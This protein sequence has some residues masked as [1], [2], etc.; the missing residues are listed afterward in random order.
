MSRGCSTII[1]KCHHGSLYGTHCIIVIWLSKKMLLCLTNVVQFNLNSA[2]IHFH[3][4]I[5]Y[6]MEN[7]NRQTPKGMLFSFELPFF[8][9]CVQISVQNDIKSHLYYLIIYLPDLKKNYFLLVNLIIFKL[10]LLSFLIPHFFPNNNRY[11][12]GSLWKF[13]L[14]TNLCLPSKYLILL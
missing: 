2:L 10:I 3:E 7:E 4:T 13:T 6:K 14:D 11:F 12:F 5:F 8:Y 1:S 9:I